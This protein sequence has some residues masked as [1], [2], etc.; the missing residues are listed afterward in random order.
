LAALLACGLALVVWVMAMVSM[1]GVSYSG[2]P[3]VPDAQVVAM[4]RADVTMLAGVIGERN[5]GNAPEALDRSA[6]WLAERLKGMGYEPREQTYDVGERT[7]KNLIV[8]RK[9]A[10]NPKELIVVGAHYDSAEG[11]PGADDNASGVAVALSLARHFAKRTPNRTLRLIFFTNEEPPY[12][13]T[14]SMGSEV[15]ARAS[16][17]ANEDIKAM[18]SLETLGYFTDEPNTQRYPFP[19]SLVYP[20]T[21]NFV[22]FVGDTGS[23]ALIRTCIRVF[24]ETAKAPS[25]G[26]AVPAFIE[27]VDWSD[28]EPYS[29]QGY[30]ALMVTDT[31]L[32]RNPHYHE[33]TDVPDQLD[34]QRLA[35]VTLGL[36]AVVE[37]LTEE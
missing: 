25:E 7:V 26:A 18:L 16:R 12:F 23:S 5:L 6:A 14:A 19:F 17:A 22:T 3:V 15:A 24:R 11:T 32:N 9:G 37:T 34:Y 10:T 20:S 4:L 29:R 1:P 33:A 2:P 21:G 36:R 28:H 31:A 13:H 8:E 30:P 35:H 27:G